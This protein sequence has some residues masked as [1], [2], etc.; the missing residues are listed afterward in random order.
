[1]TSRTAIALRILTVL[2]VLALG[3]AVA[4][5]GDDDNGSGGS[6]GGG[7]PYGGGSQASQKPASASGSGAVSVDDNAKLGQIVTDA[8][9]NTLYMFEEDK[10]GKSACYSA[11]AAVWTPY[12][13]D[14]KPKAEGGATAS[15]LGTTK[16]SDGSTQV[17][18]AGLPLY[19]YVGDKAPG[20][21]N[22]NDLDQFGAEWYALTPQGEK[23]ED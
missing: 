1:M 14:G 16:R 12:T 13:T 4:G 19:L 20:D 10:G 15:L 18:Y 11:C 17:T 6:S 5:C 9:G 7:S 23:P 8:D 22:G 2:A 3:L 21:T